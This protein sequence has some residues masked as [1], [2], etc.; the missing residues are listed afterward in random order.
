MRTERSNSIFPWPAGSSLKM[1]RAMLEG[2]LG[3]L[4]WKS[5]ERSGLLVIDLITNGDYHIPFFMSHVS[6]SMRFH[7]LI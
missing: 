5:L 4:F 6:I 7:Y 3:L 1:G 2:N